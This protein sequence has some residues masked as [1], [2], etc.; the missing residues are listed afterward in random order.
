MKLYWS[1]PSAYSRKVR[2][3]A[4]ELG[5]ADRLQLQEQSPRDNRDGF[6]GVNPLARIPALQTDDGLALYDSPVICDFLNGMVDGVFIPGA[7]P[8]RWHALRRQALGDGVLDWA[9]Q[10][11][12]EWLRD[13]AKQSA[14]LVTRCT[15]AIDRALDAADAD[16]DLVGGASF[17]IGAIAIGCALGWMD[18]R[19]PQIDWRTSRPALTQWFTRTSLRPSFHTTR[20][21]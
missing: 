11:R 2:V 15:G 17:D 21:A 9:L 20:P 8:A 5:I 3:L 14:D 4:I 13:T 7:G 6:F 1:A 16:A 19:L 12:A 18:L 10:L